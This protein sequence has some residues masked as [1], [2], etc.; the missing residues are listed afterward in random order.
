MSP[1][2]PADGVLT[3]S[4]SVLYREVFKM[5]SCKDGIRELS[6]EGRAVI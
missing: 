5:G 1:Y 2:P 6:E 4:P 3:E